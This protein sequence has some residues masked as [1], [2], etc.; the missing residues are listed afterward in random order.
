MEN[1]L[2]AFD[3]KFR[4]EILNRANTLVEKVLNYE[5]EPAAKASTTLNDKKVKD[6]HNQMVSL[7]LKVLEELLSQ[8]E[9]KTRNPNYFELL[10]NEV[11]HKALIACSIETVFFV[12]NSSNISFNT[13]LDLCEIQAFEFWRIIGSFAK[14]DPQI[15]FPI[16]KHLHSVE[17]KIIMCLAWRKG[18][19]VQKIVRQFIDENQ[20]SGKLTFPL[21][22]LTYTRHRYRELQQC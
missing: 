6:K 1:Y 19:V 17:L 13:L 8:E 12:N 15:P 3:N 5:K 9:R 20:E 4:D 16:K 10:S 14:F 11:F 22:S 21:F 18:S 2:N 7:Y